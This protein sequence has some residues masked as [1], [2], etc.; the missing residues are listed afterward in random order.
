MN[1]TS[2]KAFTGKWPT[3][4]L[5]TLALAIVSILLI[6]GCSQNPLTADQSTKNGSYFDQVYV[7]DGFSRES[8]LSASKRGG[9]GRG[10]SS[11]PVYYGEGL[12]SGKKG[13]T[14]DIN[15][16]GN[17]HEFVVQPNGMDSDNMISIGV[18]FTNYK[19]DIIARFDCGPDGLVFNHS[20]ILSFE[21][22]ALGKDESSIDLYLLGS[23]GRWKFQGTYSAD[24]N[25][26]VS[27]PIDH[28]SMYGV[29]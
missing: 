23:K 18:S 19:G 8:A 5:G 10:G 1:T 2:A 25:G 22:S 15:L 27:V 17:V 13:G 7:D 21:V 6:S 24:A 28:F 11:D 20:S 26:I 3:V 14:V 12:I 9:R 16:P 4:I 29:E